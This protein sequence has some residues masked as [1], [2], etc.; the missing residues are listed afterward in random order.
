MKKTKKIVKEPE[1]VTART[2][3]YRLFELE[4]YA[5]PDMRVLKPLAPYYDFD[6]IDEALKYAEGY[7]LEKDYGFQ[8]GYERKITILPIYTLKRVPSSLPKA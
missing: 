6:S 1:L 4:D 2:L 7:F 5:N 8:E 3:E